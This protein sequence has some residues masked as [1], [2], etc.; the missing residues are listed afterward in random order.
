M[1][2]PTK[3]S[4]QKTAAGAQ[5]RQLLSDGQE[6]DLEAMTSALKANGLTHKN[7]LKALYLAVQDGSAAVIGTWSSPK[8]RKGGA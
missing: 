8:F 5:I 2:A 1:A 6:K 7:A 4:T 3:W